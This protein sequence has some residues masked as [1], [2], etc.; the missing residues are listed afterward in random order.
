MGN[1]LKIAQL[2]NKEGNL[3]VRPA[4]ISDE[5][6]KWINKTYLNQKTILEITIV[7]SQHT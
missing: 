1:P 7:N 6:D 4:K 2:K 5:I 3:I